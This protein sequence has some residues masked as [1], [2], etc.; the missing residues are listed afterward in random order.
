MSDIVTKAVAALG[1][2]FAGSGFENTAKF[3]IEGEGSVMVDG[4]NVSAEDGEADVTL[5]AS[6]EVFEQILEGDLDP[7][8]AFMSGRLSVEGDMSVAMAMGSLL[9]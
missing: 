5:T 4:E 7:A 6:P 8:A 1:P 9:A 3:N 2:K